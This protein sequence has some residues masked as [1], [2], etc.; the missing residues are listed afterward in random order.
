MKTKALLIYPEMPLTYWGMRYA[1]RFIGKKSTIPPLGLMT[2]AAMLPEEMEVSLLD[3]NVTPLSAARVNAADLVFVS[4]MQVQEE[5]LE[6][7]I[8]LCNRLKKPVVAGGPYPSTSPERI[9]GVTHFVLNEAEV[10]LPPFIDDWRRGRAR[11]MYSDTGKPDITH[12]PPPRFD[13]V[14]TR[15]YAN[16][17][18]QYSRG[19]PFHCEFC[20]IVELFGRVP[21]TK[22]PPQFVHEMELL[23]DTGWRGALFIVD[24]NFIGN[25]NNVKQLLPHIAEFQRRNRYPFTLF[26]EATVTLADDEELMDMMIAAGFNMVFLGIETP[27]KESLQET[28]KCQNLKSDLLDGVHRIQRHGM[29]VAGGFILGFDSDPADVF[30]RQLQFIQRSGIP[31]AMVGLLAAMP[32][33]RLYR[34][35]KAENR[36]TEECHGNNTHELRL[37]FR[38]RMDVQKLL[39]GYRRLIAEIYQ[40]KKYFTRCLELLRNLQPHRTS[41]RRLR[42]PEIRAFLLS[43]LVQSFSR[44]GHHYWKFLI[45]SFRI[46][47]RLFAES[48]TMAVKGHHFFKMTRGILAVERFKKS[49]E[50]RQRLFEERVRAMRLPDPRK[51]LKALLAFR[52]RQAAA[53]AREYRRLSK[54]FRIYAAESMARFDELA[55]NL[56]QGVVRQAVE[57]AAGV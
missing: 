51:N 17:A 22:T 55:D 30:E 34:R 36:L 19:C 49:L 28:G 50:R 25:K 53:V 57:R 20:D 21:R 56:L 2:V 8:R 10:T 46:K 18:L 7:V 27:V 44:Y 45:Q 24:D 6:R 39:A 31:A 38:P 47:P 52:R 16:M 26:T 37:N 35:L 11:A 43:L 54:D 48:V 42:W 4:A 5:S 9:A 12:T 41:V 14:D 3:L 40:P 29:E 15:A 13:I 32:K 23:H 1:L 33:T